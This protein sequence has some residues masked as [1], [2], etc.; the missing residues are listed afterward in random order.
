MK[1]YEPRATKWLACF[2]AISVVSLIIGIILFVK[3]ASSFESN[4]MFTMVGFMLSIVFSTSYVASKTRWMTID[5]EKIVFH[6]SISVNGKR[7]PKKTVRFD[8]IDSV[9]SEFRKGDKIFVGDCFIHTMKLND[10]SEIE[11]FLYEYGRDTEEKIIETI[12]DR[13]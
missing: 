7:V 8:E 6:L 11:F 2:N 3:D 12:K 5:D 9:H 13:I 4:L 1:K 10:G